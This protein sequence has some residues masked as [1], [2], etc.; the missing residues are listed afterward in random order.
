[1]S[2][3]GDRHRETTPRRLFVLRQHVAPGL[4]HRFDDTIERY[5]VLA[6]AA[7]CHSRRVDRL[8]RRHRAAFDARHLHE[9]ADRIARETK[10]VLHPYLRRHFDLWHA[11]AK[12]FSER[13][14]RHRAS[15]A[16]FALTA[17]FRAG[18][19]RVAL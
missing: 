19:R 1:M 12:H 11:S 18:D 5:T 6:V 2:A 8:H 9:P 4:A 16:D 7:Q 15:D 14:G 3:L 17:D 10:V 13:P